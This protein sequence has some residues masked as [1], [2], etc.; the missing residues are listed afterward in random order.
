MGVWKKFGIK[1]NF[2]STPPSNLNYDWSLNQALLLSFLSNYQS[3]SGKWSVHDTCIPFSS[4]CFSVCLFP[5]ICF[6]LLDCE[7]ALCLGKKIARKGL[8][9][10]Y[11]LPIIWPVQG[12]V[13]RH[14]NLISRVSVSLRDMLVCSWLNTCRAL[15]SCNPYSIFKAF[16][17]E[18][19]SFA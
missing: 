5:V 19:R 13:W 2:S 4:I 9:T 3:I 16:L 14:N 1:N 18:I 11:E 6:E 12:Y 8:F 10:G 7:Q 15:R 17:L